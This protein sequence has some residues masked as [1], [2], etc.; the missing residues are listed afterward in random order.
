MRG[1]V[2]FEVIVDR[3]VVCDDTVLDNEVILPETLSILVDKVLD[4]V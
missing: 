1:N 3:E 4:K 2:T